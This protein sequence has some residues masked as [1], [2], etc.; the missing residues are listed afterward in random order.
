[1]QKCVIHQEVK[2]T[3]HNQYINQHGEKNV[4]YK[5]FHRRSKQ[6]HCQVGWRDG[7]ISKVSFVDLTSSLYPLEQ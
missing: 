3:S 4:S 7:M 1:M 5:I 2:L 6:I